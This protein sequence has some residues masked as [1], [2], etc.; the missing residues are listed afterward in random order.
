MTVAVDLE[1]APVWHV[2]DSR[3]WFNHGR[4]C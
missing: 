3:W 2:D 4:R 1:R